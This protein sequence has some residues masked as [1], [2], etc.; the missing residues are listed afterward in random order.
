MIT[1]ECL[2]VI[3]QT[4]N[5]IGQ[6][7]RQYD[8]KYAIPGAK[9]GATIG[10]RMPPK[11]T[12]RTGATL[13]AQEYVDRSTPLSVTSQ[14]GVDL[15]FTSAEL[16]LSIDDFSA[17]IIKPAM[18]QL[19]AKIESDALTAA[20]KLVANFA[21]TT[22]TAMTYDGFQENGFNL[23]QA[24]A[25][26]VDRV[27]VLNPRA[28]WKFRTDCKGLFQDASSIAK[29]YK[30]GIIGRTGGFDT[31]ENTLVP[32]HTIGTLAGTP[33]TTGAALGTSTTAT[34]WV[35]QTAVDIDGATS[36]TT[37][38]AGDILTFGTLAAGIVDCHPES[39]TSYGA[40]KRFV[41]QSD[42]TL[43]TAATAYSVTVK[44]GLMYGVGNAY[45]NCILTK[46]DTDNMTVTNWGAA[47]AQVGQS[48]FFH[49]D[50]FVFGTVDLEDVSK[51]GAWS[52][53]ENLDGISARL[54]RQYAIGSDTVP[55]RFDILWGFGGLYPELASRHINS[56]TA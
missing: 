27:G 48:L 19:I 38:K 53:R 24:V 20:Y 7:N 45:Q 31:F 54:V 23:T 17:R 15:S 47:G 55:C 4:S 5:F 3:H 52:A 29:S 43:T 56:L 9:V 13:T 14:Y 30:D 51:Y 40:L 11:Y 16:T 44:P 25:P 26:L 6:V 12:V 42:V 18:S 37:L 41:V 22:S 35:S 39:K 46:A 34:T 28:A 2:R 32:T 10:I 21:G 49:E 36:A 1:R 33:L 50:A 8:D